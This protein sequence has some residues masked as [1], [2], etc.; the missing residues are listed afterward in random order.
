MALRG[1]SEGPQATQV[2]YLLSIR[3][4]LTEFQDD[5]SIGSVSLGAGIYWLGLHNGPLSHDSRDN[6]FWETT[7][8]SPTPVT[9]HED[10][11]ASPTNPLWHDNGHSHAFQLINNPVPEPSSVALVGIGALARWPTPGA[12][13][14]RR[15]DREIEG[16][17][18]AP[19]PWGTPATPA[20]R[21]ALNGGSS[22]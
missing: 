13:R 10:D 16:P 7:S 11:L 6:M 5:F 1:V 8:T 21:A 22:A 2:C 19:S 3:P 15:P 14:P 12:A 9:G 20:L 17:R 4:G 18:E